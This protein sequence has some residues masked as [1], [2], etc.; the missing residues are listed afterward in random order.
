LHNMLEMSINILD[1]NS[2]VF[3]TIDQIFA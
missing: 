2:L 3:G 1:K